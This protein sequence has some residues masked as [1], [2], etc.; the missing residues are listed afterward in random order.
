[1]FEIMNEVIE[2]ALVKFLKKYYPEVFSEEPKNE[3]G[4]PA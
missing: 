2:P 3:D 4:V 1:M